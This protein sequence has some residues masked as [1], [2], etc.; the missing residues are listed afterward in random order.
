MVTYLSQLGI[1]LYRYPALYQKNAQIFRC[2]F[3]RSLMKPILSLQ[4][5]ETQASLDSAKRVLAL[6]Y[7]N[8]E[9]ALI[10]IVARLNC[11]ACEPEED[12]M[13]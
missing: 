5:T 7:R 8:P 3:E 6:K 12:R 10:P 2:F 1:Y 4:Q 11:C 13:N 9:I